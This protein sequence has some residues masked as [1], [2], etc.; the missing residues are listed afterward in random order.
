MEDAISNSRVSAEHWSEDKST[1]REIYQKYGRY[2]IFDEFESPEGPPGPL[3]H[4]PELDSL[5]EAIEEDCDDL[6]SSLSEVSDDSDKDNDDAID[7]ANY[8]KD[9]EDANPGPFIDPL[10]LP[11]NLNNFCSLQSFFYSPQYGGVK[12][13][14]GLKLEEQTLLGLKEQ[15]NRIKAE[16]QESRQRLRI[17]RLE[18]YH[19]NLEFKKLQGALG[20][21]DELWREYQA[22]CESLEPRFGSRDGWSVTCFSSHCDD[23][24]G[25]DPHLTLFRESAEMSLTKCNFRCEASHEIQRV[26]QLPQAM[27]EALEYSG[28]LCVEY[29]YVVHFWPIAP[30]TPR[31]GTEQ[32]WGEQYVSSQ[33]QARTLKY[34]NTDTMR[35]SPTCTVLQTKP[36]TMSP[37]LTSALPPSC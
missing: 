28:P 25:W 21:Y 3:F 34:T 37:I 7:T 27:R 13:E 16:L 31:T 26:L 32:T 30:P 33:S 36:F 9:A 22:F 2:N 11:H 14:A 29:E 23:Y 12:A 1:H 8:G 18:V 15:R 6:P 17:R 24:V 19:F 5:H 35:C 4:N 10:K 20:I